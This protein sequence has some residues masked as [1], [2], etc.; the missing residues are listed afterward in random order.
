[1]RSQTSSATWAAAIAV[2]MFGCGGSSS[3]GDGTTPGTD[4]GG[5]TDSGTTTKDGST[6][7]SGSTTT[8]S[9]STTTDTG[10]ATES[11]P[12]GNT[13]SGSADGTP[14]TTAAMALWLGSPDDAATT[15][16]YVFSKP[17]KCSDLATPGWDT[18]ITDKTQFLEMKMFGV[19]KATYTVTKSLTPAPGEAS[20]NYTLSSTSGTPVETSSSGGTVTLT[21]IADKVNVTGSF[22]LKF[23]TKDLAGTY[24]AVFCPGGHEP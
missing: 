5:T 7:D 4:S 21:T 22:A 8:D 20:V 9:G 3:S 2:F 1:M 19:T 14:F 10:P 18:R 24:D 16:V 11:G 17:V 12:G 6:D 23:G 13:I 15:V